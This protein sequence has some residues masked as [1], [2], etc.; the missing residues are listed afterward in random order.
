MMGGFTISHF[1]PVLFVDDLDAAIALYK[2]LG[3][4]EAW[5]FGEPAADAAVRRDGCTIM[6]S[7]FEPGRHGTGRPPAQ[8][9]YVFVTGVDAFHE[10]CRRAWAN[11]AEAEVGAIGDREYGMRDFRLEDPWGHRLTF[12]E[13]LE[14]IRRRRNTSGEA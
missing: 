6:F 8:F 4:S 7:R 14:L 10:H 2:R 9:T 12:G 13:G 5:R 11:E 1:M 3:F